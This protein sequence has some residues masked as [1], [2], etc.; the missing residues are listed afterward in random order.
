MGLRFK[1]RAPKLMPLEKRLMLDASLPV[2]A[3]QVLWLDAADATTIRD[4][5]GDNAATGTGGSNNGFGGTVATWVDKSG[6]GFNVTN[7]TAAQ[8]P[9]Y[10]TNAL[11]GN[12][13]LTF[14]GTNDKLTN[15]T[16]TIAGNDYTMFMVFD[17]SIAGGRDAVFEI[18]N[19]A[20]RNALFVNDSA[21][22]L[23]YYVN[24]S[25][26]NSSAVYTPGTYEVVT[27][28]QDV[29]AI[30]MWRNN[31][32]QVSAVA[33]TRV[34]TTG[35][36]VGD[37]SSG[38]DELNGHIAEII[39]YDRDLTADERRDVENYLASKW[40]RTLTGDATP[41]NGT[42][43]GAT[44]LQ[45]TN[46]TIANT[47]LASTDTDNS[48][49]ILR[50]TITDLSDYGT[51]TNTN[52]A[53]TYILG[54]SFTQADIDSG[55]IS[56]THNN[57]LNFTDVFSFTVTDGYTT[58]AAGTFNLTITPSNHAPQ[59]QGWT[60]ISSEDF[61]AGAT[62]WSDNTTEVGG[63]YLTRFLGRHAQ[64]GGAQNT[65]KTYTMTG[66]QDYTVVTFDMYKIDS[67][68]GEFFRVFINDTQSI[69]LSFNNGVFSAPVD[70]SSGIVSYTVQ[71]MTPFL[72]NFAFGSWNEQIFR[73][74]L[75]VSNSAA[76]TIK[77][78]FSST[79]DQATSDE[80]WGVDNINI[81]EVNEGGTLGP[82]GIIEN[83]VNGTVVGRVTATDQD[84]GDTISY[85]IVGG[86][87]SSAF[88]INSTTG[89]ITVAN[90]TLL[91]Y[92]SVT[93]YTLDIRATDNGTGSLFDAKT[94]TINVLD[95]PEN[96]AP[97][98]GA[99]G[100]LTV[101]ENAAN[102]TVLGTATATDAQ[103]NTIT[104]AIT[105]GNTDN[106]FAI[107]SAT[108][109]IRVSSNTNLNYDFRNTYTITVSAT[110]NGF[111]ALV[112]TRNI[113]VN[114]TNINEAPTFDIP[115]SFLNQNPY[116]RYN[117]TT[118]NF[119]QY[120]ATTAT[121]T[122]ATT[123]AGTT[124]LNGVAGHLATITSLAENTYVRG[125]GAGNLWLGASD[126]VT[127]GT[128]IWA[129]SGTEG[130][131]I[132]SS[133]SISQNGYYTNWLAGQPDNSSNEDHLEM[134]AAGVWTDALTSV[135][136][137][138]VI[139]WEGA[140][141]MAALGN[142]PFTLAENPILNQSVGFV[143]ARDADVGDTLTYSITGGSGSALFAV[144]SSTGQITVTNPAAINYESATSYTLDMRVQDI[145]GLFNTR[146]ITINISDVNETPVLNINTGTTLNEG[147]AVVVTNT[148][149]RSSDVD[150]P[151]DSAL[152]Y[153]ITDAIDHGTLVNT[154][155][156]HTYVLGETFTQ[157]DIDNGYIRYT[158]DGGETIADAFSFTVSDGT[159][160]LPASTFNIT[161]TPVNDAPIIAGYTLVSSENFEA[162]ATGWNSNTT[163][164]SAAYFTQ[165]LG[166]G[167]NDAGLQ[168]NYKTYA[169]SGTQDQVI[170][171]FDFYEIDTWDAEAFRVFINDTQVISQNFTGSITD[172]PV[173]GTSGIVS[174]TV[175]NLTP[176]ATDM[177]F[178][179][180][181]A[182]QIYR[183][184]LT[185]DTTGGNV[186]LGFG[187]TLNEGAANEAWGV[188]NINVYEVNPASG[189]VPGPFAIAETTT[190]GSLVG[191]VHATDAEVGSVLTYSII[192]GTGSG[193]FSIHSATGAI[194]VS[195]ASA[196]NYEA[197]TSYTLNVQVTD[198]GTP[199]GSDAETITI[200]VINM[201]EN[202]APSIPAA[203][204]FSVAENAALNTVVG[205]VPA[206]DAEGD[207]ITYSIT[208]GNPD[209]LFSIN[210]AGQIRIANTNY[211]NY[212]Y[213]NSYTLTVRAA[214][215][216]FGGLSSTRN[217]TVN[218]TNVNEAP[219]FDAVQRLLNTDPAL[220]YNATTG[221]F[222]KLVPSTAT[223]AAAEANANA[224]LLNGIGG[225]VT[226]INSSVENTFVRSLIT[227]SI[228]LG[229]TDSAVEGEWRLTGG[230]GTGSM[231]WLG[232]A[233]GST[234]NGLYANWNGGE[235]NNSGNE[236]SIEMQTSGLWNDT[237]SGGARPYVIEWDGTAV[238][239]SLLNGP[240]NIPEHTTVSS[241]VGSALA[242]DPDGGDVLTYSITGGT[243]SGIFNINSATGALT[244]AT[245]VNYEVANSYT[246]NL[247]VQDTA[248]LFDTL[249]IT[250]NII[251]QN[252]VPG[253]LTLTGNHIVENSATNTLI[254][255]LSTFDEDSSDTHVYSLL[256]N[257]GAKFI[258]VNGNEIRSFADIDYEQNQTFS[259]I[260]RTDD[261]HGG[262]LD[263]TFM[264]QV[265]DVLDT[266]T[267]PPATGGPSGPE[268]FIP[269]REEDETRSA[270]LLRASFGGEQG[271]SAAFYGD[272][273]QIIR[274]NLTFQV[275]DVMNGM[276][277]D[278]QIDE[279]LHGDLVDQED[280]DITLADDNELQKDFTNLREAL[281]FLQQIAD[282]HKMGD[283]EAH[284]ARDEAPRRDL[285]P[286]TIDRQFVDVMTYHKDR[287]TRLREALLQDA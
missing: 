258:I 67:W 203:G 72:A 283:A 253:T 94:I 200:N 38:G 210:A 130:G 70:G 122:A 142:G 13:V 259:I 199:M 101:A 167:S 124:T 173:N 202:T 56:Y 261:G 137:S 152:I 171:S 185:I 110:D 47:M 234:Q 244:L 126:S 136:K 69:N 31:V 68:D 20:S 161:V 231:F 223:F 251:D 265:G 114:V 107:N 228:W 276:L 7:S 105:A 235:P 32:N 104:W 65:Y 146:T 30:N 239:A 160:V 109:A 23:G 268:A 260:I 120:V 233:S 58:T 78:G 50:Y 215:N 42:N 33:G 279:F 214:D 197:I 88:S 225:Y 93:T 196:I 140:A 257:P 169:L 190:N 242:G 237:A 221:N 277:S 243:G 3:G 275:Q 141:V 207:P 89:V 90:S 14:D 79:L 163:E 158:H 172:T 227:T 229:G 217:I 132:F 74:T 211:L 201:P 274:E 112:S 230:A 150:A 46:V 285:P 63:T 139:E 271:Q 54:E 15:T 194:T 51:L 204:P 27:M 127:E 116:L 236:D 60:L 157:G 2:I 85:S 183:Y 184:T 29:T 66:T 162:G 179:V 83:S 16:A 206:T 238:I 28:M 5:D 209:G 188:D 119:Y 36:Y 226:N 77:L 241:G 170:I 222:Y 39:V 159:I 193:V 178:A 71:E 6:S 100:P 103:G 248:G 195:N 18:G 191:T 75:T 164:T 49:S 284:D 81:Y 165:F 182:D 138:Y 123:A 99:L 155:T 269:S 22:K 82:I 181:A 270:D 240:Y 12:A 52:T 220:R 113:T 266:F 129:G 84:I 131:A 19:G 25:F 95:L 176:F 24:S 208:A 118:G 250:M 115:Q 175:Q 143:N 80:S 102:N 57:T 128:W 53:H 189:G 198:N 97:V 8:R 224:T 55:Y 281:A 180:G 287:A 255:D 147:A 145:G 134:N 59:F 121:Y 48:E 117:A 272:S 1:N 154:N 35:I 249:T 174:W 245:G 64:E 135:A 256:T 37:D 98:I 286:N 133:G 246:L 96:T 11:N 247:R 192:G 267:P 166:R 26:Y 61:Q 212:E 108:G 205:T 41:V 62:G 219:S 111:G 9:T 21:N 218:I 91:N 87:G 168:T 213:M 151:P 149:L 10:T 156:A 4:G 34:S 187:S 252:D 43:T 254:G 45:G 263:R 153:T 73:F 125:L 278:D 40:G 186:K 148:M 86:T 282:T 280:A 177:G 76:A 144:N 106:I 92:E 216:G 17:R 264:I 262:I 232:T 44:V 273:Q